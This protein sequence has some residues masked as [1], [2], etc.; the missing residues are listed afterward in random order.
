MIKCKK[1]K[2]PLPETAHFCPNCGLERNPDSKGSRKKKR[3][4]SGEEAILH[5]TDFGNYYDDIIPE[6][7]EDLK[8]RK[9]DNSLVLKFVLLGFGVAVMLAACITLL[10]LFG[11]GTL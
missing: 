10:I 5:Q 3:N 8:N 11:E 6:D 2:N 1:C 7:A 4:E 9:P